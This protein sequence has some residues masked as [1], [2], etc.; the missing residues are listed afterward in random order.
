MRTSRRLACRWQSKG[1]WLGTVLCALSALGACRSSVGPSAAATNETLPATE[2]LPQLKLDDDTQN[3]LLTWV[4]EEGDFHVVEKIAEVPAERRKEVR[5]VVTDQPAGTG[6][7]VYVADLTVKRSDGTYAVTTLSRADWEKLGADRRKTRMEALAPQ[8]P[9]R[10]KEGANRDGVPDDG[11]S[12][13]GADPTL[14]DPAKTAPRPR[15]AV[16]GK[17]T[18]IVYGADWCKPCHDAERYLKSLGVAVTKKNIEESRAAQAEMQ[19]KLAHA[20]RSGSSIPVID[21]MGR[22][23]I[24]YSPSSLRQAVEAA[25]NAAPQTHG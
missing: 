3:L 18:A 4:G 1:A 24:G 13:D 21:V 17:V 9:V 12:N 11:A 15:S 7:S 19:Q 10:A 2:A 6:A 5:V 23:F 14:A 25:R 8:A 22:I 16:N 20:N